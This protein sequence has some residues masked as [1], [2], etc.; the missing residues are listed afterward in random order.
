MLLSGELKAKMAPHFRSA[1]RRRAVRKDLLPVEY[2]QK[3]AE[4][5]CELPPQGDL[6][7]PPSAEML[8]FLLI[9]IR[10]SV[11]IILVLAAVKAV[12]RKQ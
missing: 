12:E 1:L 2:M 5:G 11:R 9:C 6:G 10:S 8:H 3:G 7:W 4:Q